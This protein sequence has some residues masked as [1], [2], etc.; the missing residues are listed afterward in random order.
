MD[1][2]EVTEVDIAEA[3][4]ADIAVVMEGAIRIA[5]KVERGKTIIV[6]VE[7]E[8]VT[9]IGITTMKV[10]KEVR[11]QSLEV[12]IEVVA[13]QIFTKHQTTLKPLETRE[14]NR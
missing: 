11:E 7:E 14:K 10:E 9:L 1:I 4:E 5:K 3:T 13:E 12:D 8:E 2:A 6:E